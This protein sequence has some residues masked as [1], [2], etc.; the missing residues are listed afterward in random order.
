M[1]DKIV[2]IM[3]KKKENQPQCLQC[4]V[5]YIDESICDFCGGNP[6]M[7]KSKQKREKKKAAEERKKEASIQKVVRIRRAYLQPGTEEFEGRQVKP[8]DYFH[9]IEALGFY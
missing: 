2:S 4:G 1:F 6:T 5:Y 9:Q 7:T 8:I 3:L